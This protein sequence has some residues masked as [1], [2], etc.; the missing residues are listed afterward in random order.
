MP[1]Q[2]SHRPSCYDG[3]PYPPL[4]IQAPEGYL[5]PLNLYTPLNISIPHPWRQ[6]NVFPTGSNLH[7][8]P[9]RPS[10]PPKGP[11]VSVPSFELVVLP[12]RRPQRF[13]HMHHASAPEGDSSV[14]LH[15]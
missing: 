14:I 9:L 4:A 12:P 11:H 7:H 3:K 1:S 6:V 13:Q 15:P 8:L 2:S 5:P 10:I